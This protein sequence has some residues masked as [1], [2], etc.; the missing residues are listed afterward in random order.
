MIFK[1]LAIEPDS[2]DLSL[3]EVRCDIKHLTRRCHEVVPV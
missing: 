2:E 3:Q 1:P